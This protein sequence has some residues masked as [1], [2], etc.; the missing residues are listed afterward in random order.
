MSTCAERYIEYM[1]DYL[2]G[3]ITREHELELKKHLHECAVCREHLHSLNETV[4][5][6]KS[7]SHI[8]A[9]QGLEQKVMSRLPKKKSSGSVQKWIRRY[10]GFIAAAV[11]F[12]FMSAT[13]LGSF[14]NDDAFSVTKQPNIVIEGQT[15]I[16]PAGEVVK[17]DLVV[18]NGDLIIEGEVDGNVTVVN[19][20]YM[21]SSAVVTGQID[22]VD[23][24]FER[25]WYEM[26]Q[27][28]VGIVDVFNG[29]Q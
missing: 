20:K 6:I 28:G 18:K 16:V 17:G 14:S 15:A 19:G 5:F 3:D 9:P 29:E 10:P 23:K 4:V 21:A 26:K 13:L 2:D 25:I 12:L 22:E 8:S 24:T 11:F 27:M 1:H 7:A